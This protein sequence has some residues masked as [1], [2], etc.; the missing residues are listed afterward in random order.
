MRISDW[1]SDV[2]SSDLLALTSWFFETFVLRDF[3]PGYAPYDDRFAFLF[4]S[5]YEAEGQRHAR[6]RRGM[7]TRPAL[8]EVLAYRAHVEAALLDALPGL[9][10]EVRDLV[11]LGCHHE[12][13]HQELLLTDILHLLSCNPIEPPLWPAPRQAPMAMPG[14]IGW[15]EGVAATVELG[16]RSEEH[17][18]E[19]QSLMRISY[20]GF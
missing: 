20:A 3:L 13:Q 1:S 18:S 4:N 6:G 7:V 17:T 14:A 15:I 10:P 5:Y 16:H 12:E 11:A 19:L 9:P 2:C 8:D